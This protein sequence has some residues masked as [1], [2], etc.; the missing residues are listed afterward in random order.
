LFYERTILSDELT[1][2]NA[3]VIGNTTIIVARKILLK[4]ALNEGVIVIEIDYQVSRD[5]YSIIRIVN[6]NAIF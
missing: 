2:I 3:A 4:K 5:N 1:K 6:S